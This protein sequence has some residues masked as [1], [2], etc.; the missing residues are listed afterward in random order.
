VVE[1][2]AGGVLVGWALHRVRLRQVARELRARCDERVNERTREAR[3]LLDAFLQT[4]EGSKLVAEDAL[5]KPEDRAAMRKALE[6]L[7]AWLAQAT[8]EGRAAL[9]AV[10]PT[11][12][13]RAG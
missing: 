2:V 9:D 6:T 11:T 7:A 12:Q 5:E 10:G 13:R 4:V 8:D 1:W 3:E